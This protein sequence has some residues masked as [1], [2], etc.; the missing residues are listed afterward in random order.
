MRNIHQCYLNIF[1]LRTGSIFRLFMFPVSQIVMIK[2]EECV[3]IWFETIRAAIIGRRW[4]CVRVTLLW[5]LMVSKSICQLHKYRCPCGYI[6]RSF[7]DLDSK[8]VSNICTTFHIQ[9]YINLISSV[10]WNCGLEHKA[11]REGHGFHHF[12]TSIKIWQ[13]F[14]IHY[15]AFDSPWIIRLRRRSTKSQI[16]TLGVNRIFDS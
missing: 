10:S 11:P 4:K 9:S 3:I 6:F 1:K 13:D 8:I 15:T 7:V 2:K 12:S 16:K 5:Q 14:P